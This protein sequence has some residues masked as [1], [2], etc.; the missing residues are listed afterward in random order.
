MK[1]KMLAAREDLV[2]EVIEVASRRGFTL[3]ALTNEA[4]QRVIEADRMGLSLSEVADGCKVLDA[5]KRGGFV[6]VPEMLLYEVLEKAYKETKD[7]MIKVW[8]ESGEWFG[9]YYSFKNPENNIEILRRDICSLFWN[10]GEFNINKN[11]NGGFSVKCVG[12]RF[13]ESYAAFLSA[14]LEGAFNALGY[15][16]VEKHFAKGFVNLKFEALKEG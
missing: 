16:C 4:L 11:E 8:A 2:N 12:S 5:A 15:R 3:Y 10:V 1:R 13:P 14:F 7:W 9:K 6:L